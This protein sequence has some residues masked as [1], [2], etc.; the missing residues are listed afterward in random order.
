MHRFPSTCPCCACRTMLYS[1]TRDV[2]RPS[3]GFGREHLACLVFIRRWKQ[4]KDLFCFTFF[5]PV[6]RCSQRTESQVALNI[7]TLLCGMSF[8]TFFFLMSDFSWRGSHR[9]NPT[10]LPRKPQTMEMMLSYMRSQPGVRRRELVV[11]VCG[12]LLHVLLRDRQYHRLVH[13]RDHA[14]LTFKELN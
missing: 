7:I 2:W 14:A 1:S 11:F 5:S 9:H 10:G 8:A 12:M 3:R 6:R 13:R 4:R